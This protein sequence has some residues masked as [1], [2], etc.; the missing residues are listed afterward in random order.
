[1]TNKNTGC[2]H[3]SASGDNGSVAKSPTNRNLSQ[4]KNNGLGES[5]AARE[6]RSYSRLWELQ[7]PRISIFIHLFASSRLIL[8]RTLNFSK[9]I[10]RGPCRDAST[11][12][13]LRRD[14]NPP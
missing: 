12:L 14:L 5:Y 11:R 13:N 6:V 10:F 2:K 9:I 7:Y 1:M 3:Q 8:D 4:H